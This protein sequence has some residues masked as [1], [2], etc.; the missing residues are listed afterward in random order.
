MEF[1]SPF[2]NKN[3]EPRMRTSDHIQEKGSVL[4]GLIGAV[5]AKRNELTKYI[6]VVQEIA[7][8]LAE[9]KKCVILKENGRQ[10]AKLGYGADSL[11]MRLINLKHVEINDLSALMRLIKEAKIG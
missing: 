9:N 1:I 3:L 5:S 8:I 11:G 6:S 7:T 4:L 10:L 2:L